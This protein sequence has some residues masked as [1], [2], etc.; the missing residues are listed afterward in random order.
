MKVNDTE[1]EIYL[2][3]LNYE[4]QKLFL[5]AMNMKS[6]EDGNYEVF[7]IAVVPIPE[8]DN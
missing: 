3:D 1:I 6:E 8:E 2:S 7:P 5:D 4:A